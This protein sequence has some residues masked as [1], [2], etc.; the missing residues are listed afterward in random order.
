MD[1]KKPRSIFDILFNDDFFT[2]RMNFSMEDDNFPKD[3]DSNFS[4]TEETV[5]TETHF[6]KK[7]TWTSID[8]A[9][10]F[11]RTSMTSK[12]T[13]KTLKKPSK[14]ELQALLDKAVEDQEYEKAI[15]YRDELS[16]L[17]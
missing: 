4:K 3:D 11:V 14:E 6:I 1:R 17:E 13:H 8:G 5:E 10:K 9:Q 7:E 12:Q 16:K 2:N 15:E